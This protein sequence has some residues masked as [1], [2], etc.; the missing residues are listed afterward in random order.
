MATPGHGFAPAS[1]SLST[2]LPPPPTSP[3][4]PIFAVLSGDHG[5]WMYCTDHIGSTLF[6]KQT[7]LVRDLCSLRQFMGTRNPTNPSALGAT[8]EDYITITLA[9]EL[10]NISLTGVHA[11]FARY[12][13]MRNSLLSTG[14]RL[15]AEASS[16]DPLWDN[17]LRS[18]DSAAW[19]PFSWH[20]KIIIGRFLQ[21]VRQHVRAAGKSVLHFRPQPSPM[22]K[23]ENSYRP[24]M[25]VH[26]RGRKFGAAFVGRVCDLRPSP[27]DEIFA[28]FCSTSTLRST[29]GISGCMDLCGIGDCDESHNSF[30]PRRL[31]VCL[32][33]SHMT[34]C[35]RVPRA[36][37]CSA[38]CP[39][40][41]TPQRSHKLP[42][43]PP[44]RFTPF[45]PAHTVLDVR[46]ICK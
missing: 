14:G 9:R 44:S 27:D 25:L 23:H 1:S 30:R 19:H 37:W 6:A 38:Y 42:L 13:D 39:W 31:D 15:L 12:L 40:H 29:I 3:P 45:M 32:T 4:S 8:S 46:M 33:D 43:Q 11:K 35:R 5:P 21:G 24:P 36:P 10:F 28:S 34:C 16:F 26:L 20:G 18:D 7:R 2:T 17:Q 22:S 41:A